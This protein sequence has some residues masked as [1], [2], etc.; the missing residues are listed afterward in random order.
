METQE[1]KINPVPPQNPGGP[2][3]EF[4]GH[5]SGRTLAG[6]VIIT[7]GGALLAK[8]VLDIDIPWLF[9]WPMLLVG[10]GIYIGAKHSFRNPVWIIP[11][12]IG[13][14]FLINNY[15][16]YFDI[17]QYFWPIF[18][19]AIGLVMIFKSKRRNSDYYKTTF[20]DGYSESHGSEDTIDCV[21][22]FGG[23]KK[24]IISKDFKGGEA[25]TF[26][27]GTELNLMQ[28]DA[29]Q[30]IVL[31][32]TQVFGGTKLIIP[33]HWRVNAEEMVTIFGGL[34]DKRPMPIQTTTT[35]YKIIVLKGTCIFGGI[36]I[37][38]Y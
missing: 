7:I 14:A 34:N 9:S 29:S 1:S 37:K 36:D 28:A 25:I 3:N 24:N 27:G 38:S 15:Y 10:I 16:W 18:I 8:Q 30:R 6:L 13:V 23:I 20:R 12:I 2:K 4:R 26:F 17:R 22:V 19:I 31:D 21:T 5:E 11:V 33:P 35:D 32:L